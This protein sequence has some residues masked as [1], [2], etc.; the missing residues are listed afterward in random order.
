MQMN[1]GYENMKYR[2]VTLKDIFVG[3]E[4]KKLRNIYPNKLG[5]RGKISGSELA[6]LLGYQQPTIANFENGHKHIPESIY[7]KLEEIFELPSGYF[8]EKYENSSLKAEE[9][10]NYNYQNN[11]YKSEAIKNIE[12]CIEEIQQ[13]KIANLK[14]QLEEIKNTLEKIK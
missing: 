10:A 2:R 6:D 11:T 13:G 3:S 7:P 8:D 5:S 1:I 9:E 4:I 14:E 12:I